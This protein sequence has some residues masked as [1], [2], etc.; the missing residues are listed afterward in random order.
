MDRGLLEI[1]P[2]ELNFTFEVKKQSS[3]SIQLANKSDHYVAF[4]VKTTSPKKY[5]VRPNTGIM[6]P[7]SICD[8]TVTMQAQKVAPADM[9]CKDKFLI[10]GTVVPYGMEAEAIT[11]DLF[12]KGNGRYI[13]ENKLRVFL[14]NPPQSP[15]Y[16]GLKDEYESSA[17]RTQV[18]RGVENLPPFHKVVS[19]EE[20]VKSFKDAEELKPAKDAVDLRQA[21]DIEFKIAE[22][23]E[24]FKS[25]KDVKFKLAE[26][27]EEL[28]PAKVVDELKQTKDVELKLAKDM[29][30]L[31]VSQALEELKSAMTMEKLE[32]TKDVEELKSRLTELA[33][34]LSE[35]EATISTLRQERST[36][37]AEKETMHKQLI[38][39]RRNKGVRR[40]QAGFP[41]LFVCMVAL[42]AMA[43]GYR[44]HY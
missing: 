28:K 22:D 10:Q 2:R 19:G 34:K 25:A 14:V 38:M 41:F 33:A 35:A 32:L 1:V 23:A 15:V 39:L 21:K 26:D 17:L 20:H 7:K 6:H 42:I 5:C 27:M 18:L 13:E 16:G 40:E 24:E 44:L 8:F 31:E 43:I 37:V 11:P 9:Q 3:C 30:E 29:K 12:V 36:T 4:K